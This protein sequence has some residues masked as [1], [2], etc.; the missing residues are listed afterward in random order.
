MFDRMLVLR[1][2]EKEHSSVNALN[3][4]FWKSCLHF[5]IA[6]RKRLRRFAGISAE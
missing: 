6:K 5:G 4:L 1:L 3:D 2:F